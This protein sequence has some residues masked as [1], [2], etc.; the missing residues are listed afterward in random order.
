MAE[1]VALDELMQQSDVVTLHCP[2]TEETNHLIDAEKIALMKKNAILINCARGPVVDYEALAEALKQNRISGAGVD[3]YET[4]PPIPCSH[5]M[6]H[7][8]NTIVTPHIAFASEESMMLRAEIVFRNLS[9]WMEG[10][11]IQVSV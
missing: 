10:N 6:L 3:V 8:P 7:T 2:L 5:V 1:L 9:E 4:E 11:Q